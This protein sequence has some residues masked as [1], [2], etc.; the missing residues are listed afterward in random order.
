MIFTTS[1][2]T[3]IRILP[4]KYVFGWYLTDIPLMEKGVHPSPPSRIVCGRKLI[5]K[6]L[7]S[8]AVSVS[9]VILV[10]FDKYPR[11]AGLLKRLTGTGHVNINSD[12]S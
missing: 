8:I 7:N 1:F 12:N 6:K 3:E 4:K 9:V 11:R 10:E 5:I 2:F